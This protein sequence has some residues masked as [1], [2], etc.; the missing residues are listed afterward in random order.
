MHNLWYVKLVGLIIPHINLGI[1]LVITALRIFQQY[2]P[3]Y[4]KQEIKYVRYFHQVHSVHLV[5]LSRTVAKAIKFLHGQQRPDGSWYGTWAICFTYA[6]M[7]ALE[8]LALAGETYANSPR[9]KRACQFLLSKQMPDGGWGESW[10]VCAFLP[11]MT[12]MFMS[13]TVVRRGD[14]C[15]P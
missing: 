11:S 4:R 12:R 5:Y 9:V 15:S 8:S 3:E 10:R 1:P 7:F 14:I 13:G 2:Y 6:T